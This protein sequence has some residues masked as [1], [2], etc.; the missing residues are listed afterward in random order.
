[1]ELR[2][3]SACQ[4]P[5]EAAY[6]AR[7][8][9]SEVS[10]LFSRLRRNH[11]RISV[12]VAA[13]PNFMK[14]GPVIR[15]LEPS[16]DV[17]LVHTGQHYDQRMSDGFFE[18]LRLPKPDVNLEVGS[19]THA[20]Q[21]AGVMV[22][23]ESYLTARDIDVVVV[24]GDVN[25]TVACA[26]AAVKLH[27]PVAHV[28]AGLRSRDWTM[29]EEVNRV[30]TDRI[31]RWL[32]TTSADADQN[33]AAE[34]VPTE[35]VHLTGN[36]MIDTLLDN[37]DRARSRGDAARQT[38]GL[39]G[40][41][42]VLTLHR[43][44]N[45]DAAASFQQL[46]DAVTEVAVGVPFVFPAHPRTAAKLTEFGITLPETVQVVEPL[47]YL[48]FIGLVEGAQL[49]LTDSG[50]VQEETSILGVPCITLRENTERPI[51]CELGTNRLVGTDPDAV[52]SAVGDAL[53]TS[54]QPAEIPLWD[55]KAGGRIAD[56]L[57][58]DLS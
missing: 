42:G 49:V 19:G 58:A 24:V 41:Y 51:T 6:A 25:S 31:S 14:V 34:G 47:G 30:L 22:A 2:Q 20:E 5:D 32:F 37:L 8:R 1:V 57:L 9:L 29:P 18:D 54:R 7:R 56:V 45:V 36:V 11:P 44:S 40:R 4:A 38:H 17:E 50:G 23:Y 28:E 13:R 43:P 12:V 15:A 39:D 10:S 16:A 55:G 35:W 27:I 21:T 48:D 46:V 3:P 53:V 33:L 26:M 52:R